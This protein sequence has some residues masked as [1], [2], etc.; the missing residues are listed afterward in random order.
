MQIIK[1]AMLNINGITAP[2][3][4]EMLSEFVQRQEI[5]IMLVQEATNPDTLNIRGYDTYHNIGTSM[6]GTAIVARK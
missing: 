1:I 4:V 2:R 3:R 6:C 5:D